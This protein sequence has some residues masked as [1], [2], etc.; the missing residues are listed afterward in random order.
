[1]NKYIKIDFNSLQINVLHKGYNLMVYP[2]DGSQSKTIATE[3]K[4]SLLKEISKLI[5]DAEEIQ[6]MI[7]NGVK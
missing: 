7:N 4:K 2:K 6:S 3:T 1:M 5:D